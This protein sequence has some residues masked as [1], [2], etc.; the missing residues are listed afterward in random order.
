MGIE[1]ERKFL[2]IGEPWRDSPG[3]AFRQGYLCTDPAR[4]VR[5]RLAGAHG[6]LTIKG[7]SHGATRTEYEYEIPAAEAQEMLDQLCPGPQIEKTRYRLDEDGLIW[8]VDV[9]AGENAGLVLAEVEL[10]D[11]G[12]EIALPAWVGREVTGDPRY[13]NASLSRRPFTTWSVTDETA[14]PAAPCQIELERPDP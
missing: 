14:D 2:V 3:V 6:Y 8:E 13:Y 1:I 11:E 12:Q 4:T 10:D 9:F 7:E 5:V